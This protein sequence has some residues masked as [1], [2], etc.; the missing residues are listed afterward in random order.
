[1]KTLPEFIEELRKEST[2]ADGSQCGGIKTL[3]PI[4][5][6]GVNRVADLL[7]AWLDE[8]DKEMFDKV[9]GLVE[10]ATLVIEEFIEMS[11][12]RIEFA[13]KSVQ[14]LSKSTCEV[15]RALK[16]FS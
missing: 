1:M 3:K 4:V 9:R 15:E 6:V 5:D 10:A 14:Q 11:E 16:L 12:G 7:Q 8:A 13:P 2:P